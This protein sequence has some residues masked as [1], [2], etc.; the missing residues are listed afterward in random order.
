MKKIPSFSWLLPAMALLF[1]ESR[2]ILES[3]RIFLSW[4]VFNGAFGVRLSAGRIQIPEG[5]VLHFALNSVAMDQQGIISFLNL[6]GYLLYAPLSLLIEKM[7]YAPWA[8]RFLWIVLIVPIL[9]VPA[10]FFSGRAIDAFLGSR[11][12]FRG[13]MILSIL[14]TLASLALGIGLTLVT[15]PQERAEQQGILCWV[16]TGTFLWSALFA[17]PA[18]TWF[19]QR[20]DATNMSNEE[21]TPL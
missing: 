17:L 16:I 11:R 13:E 9:A 10:W 3:L 12:L 20:R 4:K 15:S 21:I 18:I 6:P 5:E 19:R 7:P 8:V 14:L 1:S 2:I